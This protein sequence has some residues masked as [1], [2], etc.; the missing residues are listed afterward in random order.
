MPDTADRPN[1]SKY[2][3]AQPVEKPNVMKSTAGEKSAEVI[4]IRS[5]LSSKARIA[6]RTDSVAIGTEGADTSS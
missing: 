2:D 3:R 1:S 5:S 4:R 6:I